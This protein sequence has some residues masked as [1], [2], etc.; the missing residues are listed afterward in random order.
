MLLVDEYGNTSLLAKS[1][2]INKNKS[3]FINIDSNK[4]KKIYGSK[5]ENLLLFSITVEKKCLLI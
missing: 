3:T 1:I 4:S 2:D 5:I